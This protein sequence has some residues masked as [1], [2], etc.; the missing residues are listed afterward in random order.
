MQ[1]SLFFKVT[2]LVWFAAPPH[3]TH[4]SSRVLC[5]LNWQNGIVKG[6]LRSHTNVI[7][8]LYMECGIKV[9]TYSITNT[10]L[11]DLC[12]SHNIEHN[13]NNTMTVIRDT[14]P[15]M[16]CYHEKLD[17]V[18]CVMHFVETKTIK[19]RLRFPSTVRLFN[20][21]IRTS[22]ALLSKAPGNVYHLHGVQ[23]MKDDA[24]PRKFCGKGIYGEIV[25]KSGDYNT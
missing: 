17:L 12:T 6:I 10:I 2:K 8:L 9:S 14:G 15:D 11:V 5:Y 18:W 21:K 3:L 23:L 25:K 16:S 24:N 20:E 19:N 22:R 7:F 4:I 13:D 1:L